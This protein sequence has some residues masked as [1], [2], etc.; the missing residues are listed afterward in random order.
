MMATPPP[1]P[2][3]SLNDGSSP[4]NVLVDINNLRKDTKYTVILAAKNQ[5]GTTR[6]EMVT[7][8]TKK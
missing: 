5:Y 1:L 7:F 6:G 8:T 3:Q 2:Q 4:A